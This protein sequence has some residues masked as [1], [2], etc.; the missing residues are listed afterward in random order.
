M[1]HATI[2]GRTIRFEDQG[3]GGTPL[4]LLHGGMGCVETL[5]P[6]LPALAATRRVIAADLPG[7]GGSTMPDGPFSAQAWADDLAALISELGLQQV[8]VA[9]YSMGGKAA[10]RLAIQHPDAVRRLVLVSVA[11]RRAGNH[12][13]V[14]STM[15][16]MGPEMAP[17]L[18]QSP[19]FE[20][21]SAVAPDPD[22]FDAMV[23]K[24]AAAV[25]EDFDWTGE[26]SRI[27]ARPL[28]V[29]ADADS[30]R[31]EHVVEVFGLLGGGLRDA[32][33]D[34]SAR[35]DAQLAVLPGTTHYDITLSPALPAV[36]AP[37]LDA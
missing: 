1:P 23:L 9:G 24:T 27:T 35:P 34:G 5:G 28:L 6:L 3:A 21:F 22:G 31:P 16:A 36:I 17:M 25:K 29:F 32:G 11:W 12:A 26:A 13:D 33:V 4:L 18:R 37:F 15:D 19:L 2:A 20:L 10:L 14:L 8:D 7:H 30:I